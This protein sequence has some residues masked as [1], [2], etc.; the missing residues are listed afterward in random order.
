MVATR[1]LPA[2]HTLTEQQ[3]RG[4]SCVWCRTP[5]G[6]G[7]GADLGE[8][9]VRPPAGAAYSWFPRE[10]LDRPTCAGQYAR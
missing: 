1:Q 9:R 6:T 4:W 3:Q 7:L 10:C 5:L 8:Q 2:V